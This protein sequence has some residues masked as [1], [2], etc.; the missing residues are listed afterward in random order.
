MFFIQKLKTPC[1]Y[2]NNNNNN[3]N[4]NSIVNNN[5]NSNNNSNNNVFMHK[6]NKVYAFIIIITII[7]T[8]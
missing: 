1:V 6:L 3:N 4:N 7:T 5:N 8:V 2:N